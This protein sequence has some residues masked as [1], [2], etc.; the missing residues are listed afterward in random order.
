MPAFSFE[1]ISGPVRHEPAAEHEEKEQRSVIT[2][3][4]DRFEARMKIAK[5]TDGAHAQFARKLPK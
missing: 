3:I 1:K 4:L 2:Q 5:P